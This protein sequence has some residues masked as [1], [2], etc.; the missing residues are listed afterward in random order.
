MSNEAQD[1]T[2]TTNLRRVQ[3]R[4]R[5]RSLESRLENVADDLR[6]IKLQAAIMEELF[7][8]EV[9]VDPDLV[10]KVVEARKHAKENEYDALEDVIED[11][12]RKADSTRT[13]EQ[14]LNKRLVSR[15]NQVG[16]MVQINERVGAYNHDSLEELH[17]LF[18]NWNWQEAASMEGSSD[19][20]S[21]LEECRSFGAEMREMYQDARSA[22]IEPLANEGIEDL[23]ESILGSKTVHLG[24]LSAEEREKLAKSDL[25]DYLAIS[26]G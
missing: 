17:S 1:H 3:E 5:R 7:E 22:I 11:L 19:F 20:G 24:S 4:Y 26:L 2:L 25:G 14:S 23:V 13:I 10:Q 9:E 12:E 15:E 18:A 8:T 6:D 21:Q 16:A